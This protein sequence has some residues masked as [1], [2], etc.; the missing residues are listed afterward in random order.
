MSKGW[1]GKILGLP[2]LIEKVRALQASGQTVVQSHGVFDLIHPGIVQHLDEARKLG[3][4]VVV[5]VIRDEDVHRGPGRPVFPGSLRAQ[6][7]AAMAAVDYVALV[8]D[9]EPFS[10]VR[11]IQPDVFSRGQ[12]YHERDRKI[13]ERI[14]EQER[15]MYFGKTR[16]LETEGFSFTDSHV[17]DRLLEVLPP[18]T[19]PF[20]RR[21]RQDHPFERIA[22][23]KD[24]AEQM[25]TLRE[26]DR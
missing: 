9:S 18:E 8:A 2:E 5:T 20:L 16:I 25:R 4:A 21:F 1:D 15:E 19:P 11:Q 22:D 24:V 7:V 17:V 10:C 14:F 23:A 3:D 6:N 13:H 12:A 26:E